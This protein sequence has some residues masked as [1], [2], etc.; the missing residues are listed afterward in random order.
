[1]YRELMLDSDRHDCGRYQSMIFN[2]KKYSSGFTL[3]EVTVSLFIL[4]IAITAILA[5]MTSNDQAAL[6]VKNNYIASGLVQEG[7]EIVRNLRDTDS[8]ADL[9]FGASLADG[10]YVGQW[11]STTLSSV[12]EGS[13][14][15]LNI[16]SNNGLYSYDAGTPTIFKRLI[17]VSTPRDGIEKK[18]VVTVSWQERSQSKVVTAENHLLNWV[19]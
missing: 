16:N 19:P 17:T 8:L 11:N 3:I 14:P 13:Q 4:S 1:M 2:S 9:S 6:S 18:I 12:N 5:L 15:F 7:M 10:T